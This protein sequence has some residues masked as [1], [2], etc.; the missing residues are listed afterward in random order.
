[1]SFII[2]LYSL[3]IILF[4]FILPQTCIQNSNSLSYCNFVG[5]N[6][7]ALSGNNEVTISYCTFSNYTNS[8]LFN[9]LNVNVK[10]EHSV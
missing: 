9:N 3:C 8:Q 1:M 10:I 7:M 4:H 5:G 2:I 6:N